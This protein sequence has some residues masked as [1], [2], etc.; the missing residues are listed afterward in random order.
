MVTPALRRRRSSSARRL[1]TQR[2][3]RL[4]TL[5]AFLVLGAACALLP[6]DGRSGHRGPWTRVADEQPHETVPARGPQPP[7]AGSVALRGAS[8][9]PAGEPRP[10]RDL[11]DAFG[12]L[13]RSG[14]PVGGTCRDGAPLAS[15]MPEDLSHDRC[16]ANGLVTPP[17]GTREGLDGLAGLTAADIPT[18]GA[19]TTRLASNDTA[20]LLP[21]WSVSGPAA[22]LPGGAPDDTNG[23]AGPN[24]AAGRWVGPRGFGGGAGAGGDP[25]HGQ[26]HGSLEPGGGDGGGANDGG[27]ETSLTA[28]GGS[29]GPPRP[30]LGRRG[31]PGDGGPSG[32]NTAEPGIATLE[33]ILPPGDTTGGAKGGLD[34]PA[35]PPRPRVPE[36]AAF[37]LAGAGLLALMMRRRP[38]A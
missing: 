24:G 31:T 29:D 12:S 22:W 19:E 34:T 28:P 17:A 27:G 16:H 25:I 35:A 9:V 30:S 15:V 20:R 23:G 32:G 36:P 8:A 21:W 2:R 6:R 14:L 13:D 7:G 5:A 18:G 10:L 11:L 37:V 4:A 1:R 38:R 3:R 26:G 33:E